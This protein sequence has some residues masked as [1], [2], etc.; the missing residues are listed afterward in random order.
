[1]FAISRIYKNVFEPKEMSKDI[2]NQSL[3]FYDFN[4]PADTHGDYVTFNRLF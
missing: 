4:L 1:M 3:C 2:N